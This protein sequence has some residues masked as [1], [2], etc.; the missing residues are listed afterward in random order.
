MNRLVVEVEL[1]KK[2]FSNKKFF[3]HKRVKESYN[4]RN[5]SL[6]PSKLTLLDS[7]FVRGYSLQLE[8][9]LHNDKELNMKDVLPLAYLTE[10]IVDNKFP[11][12]LEHNLSRKN[13]EKMFHVLN[14]FFEDNMDELTNIYKN[15][16]NRVLD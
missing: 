5:T 7:N 1:D 6:Y 15:L 10:L 2:K 8:K 4:I 11:I 3:T 12:Y 13:S 9:I 16:T 14:K